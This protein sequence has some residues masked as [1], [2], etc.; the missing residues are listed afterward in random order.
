MKNIFFT[1][2]HSSPQRNLCCSLLPP[3]RLCA[4]QFARIETEFHLA[5][6]T[7]RRSV[8]CLV[9]TSLAAPALPAQRTHAAS[10]RFRRQ[11]A[12]HTQ[13]TRNTH[14]LVTALAV[15]THV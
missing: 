12:L 6:L 9:S 7:L 14:S 13:R 5:L 15:R 11:R 4:R 1:K 10:H 2:Q 3:V 8:V